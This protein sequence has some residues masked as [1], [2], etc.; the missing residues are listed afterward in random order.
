M[1]KANVNGTTYFLM[2][3]LSGNHEM[4]GCQTN[5]FVPI[6]FYLNSNSRP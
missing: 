4:F 6:I 1:E 3:T 2:T 5:Q